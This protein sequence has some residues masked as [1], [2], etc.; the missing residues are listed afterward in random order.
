MGIR[1]FPGPTESRPPLSR[2]SPPA[3]QPHINTPYAHPQRPSPCA[4]PRFPGIAH[5]DPHRGAQNGPS[6]AAIW[7]D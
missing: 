1:P 5:I 6:G 2:I 3:K 7:R 4:K